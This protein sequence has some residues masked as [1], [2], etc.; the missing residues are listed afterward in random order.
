MWSLV[1]LQEKRPTRSTI[2]V[3]EWGGEVIFSRLTAREQLDVAAELELLADDDEEARGV[4]SMVSLVSRSVV[5][6]DGA[7]VFDSDQGR[8]FLGTESLAI[9]SRVGN[10][11][12]AL[13][14]LGTVAEE[15]GA[16]QKKS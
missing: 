12:M 16:P 6:S 2:V 7:R 13:H 4:G 5:D 1:Q 9:L 11:A 10:E 15:N 8:E 3:P 14:D